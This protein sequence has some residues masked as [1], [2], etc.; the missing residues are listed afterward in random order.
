MQASL[1]VSTPPKATGPRTPGSLAVSPPG[2]AQPA[3]PRA[4]R[5]WA[6]DVHAR[7]WLVTC[8]AAGEGPPADVPRPGRQTTAAGRTHSPGDDVADELLGHPSIIEGDHSLPVHVSGVPVVNVLFCMT[9]R[10]G[11]GQDRGQQSAGCLGRR[12]PGHGAE[13][14]GFPACL[15]AS[16][17]AS[18]HLTS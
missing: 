12:L 13:L 10:G 9:G 17:A 15:E 7:C 1:P 14:R 16:L 3:Q 18:G 8:T 5:A 2:P 4:R 11:R 6:R